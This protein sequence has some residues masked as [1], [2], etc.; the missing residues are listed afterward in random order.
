ML[1]FMSKPD[2]SF[3]AAVEGRRRQLC[4]EMLRQN[5]QLTLS[6]LHQLAK[7]DLGKLLATITVKDLLHPDQAAQP[8]DAAAAPARG[9]ASGPKVAK[10]PVEA[11]APAKAAAPPATEEVNTRTAA[12][13]AVFDR[14]VFEAIRT[15]GGAV[16]AGAIQKR[17]GGT[18]MQVRSACNRLIEAGQLTW[19]GKARGTR[20]SVA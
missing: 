7:G 5:L 17:V 9:K 16:G 13:R 10:S 3:V 4:V 18:N 14:A 6:E 2:S 8:R 19:T 15:I 11:K 1:R 20:Y 12:G